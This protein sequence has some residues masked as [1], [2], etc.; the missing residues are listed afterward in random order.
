M[1]PIQIVFLALAVFAGL[2]LYVAA[3]ALPEPP[4]TRSLFAREPVT[5]TESG[6]KTRQANP[7]ALPVIDVR[8]ASGDVQLLQGYQWMSAADADII[9][10]AYPV[11]R[12]FE[13]PRWQNKLWRGLSGAYDWFLL[14]ISMLASVVLVF[15]LRVLWKL[16]RVN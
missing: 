9:V 4:L 12:A 13:A 6:V 10:A 14:I 16:R 8:D 1:K 5:V 3:F 11:G 7:S 15:A 2:I